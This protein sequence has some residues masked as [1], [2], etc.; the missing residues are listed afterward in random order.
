[1][2]F[3]KENSNIFN[4][5]S[6]AISEGIIVVNREQF[7]VATNNS[8]NEMFGYSNGALI[9]KP[10]NTL[11]PQK[12][13]HNHGGHFAGFMQKSNK[14]QM[15]QGRDLFGMRKN[16][17]E[18]PV[19]AGLNPFEVDGVTYVMALVIDITQRKQQ[20][21]QI[22]ELNSQLEAKIELRT[23]ELNDIVLELRGEVNL[24]KEAESKAKM[25]LKKE[26][27]LND[28]K[29]KFLS[30]VSHEFKT[31]LSSILTSATL[32]SKY[33]LS[34]QQSKRDKHLDTIKNKVKYLDT[35]LTDFLSVERLESGKVNYK[36][37][38]FPLSKLVNEVIYDAN[39]LLKTGQNIRYPD[40]IDDVIIDFDEKILELILSNLIH[41]AIKY[42][43][44]YA[45]IDIQVEHNKKMVTLKVIDQGMGIP[46]EEQKYIFNRYFRAE[47]ALLTQ[48]TGIGLNIVKGHLENLG[49][50]IDFTSQENMGS[51]F[52]IQ[53]PLLHNL[54]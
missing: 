28:L 11:I 41:N 52:S 48:G 39:M 31:P 45:P 50:S 22:S 4:L 53:L 54:N 6:S 42:S 17:E 20:E 43:P 3:F 2:R 38:T 44:E 15:G 5:L 25:A 23:R 16:G 7:I 46:K 35:I 49:G 33:Q 13:H 9:G 32:I 47:N 21:R 36:F 34:D 37:T 18:F 10:L 40:N 24:R 26:R 29:T 1:M 27:E 30:L 51:T 12:F 8:A 14:R 19:E